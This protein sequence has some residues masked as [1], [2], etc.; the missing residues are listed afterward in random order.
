MALSRPD[1]LGVERTAGWVPTDDT[2]RQRGI[3]PAALFLVPNRWTPMGLTALGH[4]LTVNIP[5][6]GLVVTAADLAIPYQ[7]LHFQVARSFDAQEQYAQYA[8]LDSHPNTDPRIHFFA[9]WQLAQEANVSAVWHETFPELLVAD[10]DG[11]TGLYYRTYPTFAMN[12]RDRF[13]VEARLRAYGVPGRTLGALGWSYDD[14]DAILRSRQGT[15]SILAGNFVPETMVDPAVVKLFRFDATTG[16]AHRYSSDFAYHELIDP[17]GM[18]EVTVQALL[19]DS[20]DALGHSVRF[21][22][23]EPTPPHRSYRITDGTGRAFRLD[24]EDHVEYLDGELPGSHVKAFVVSRAADETRAADNTVEYRYDNGRLVETRYPGHA[25]GPARVRRYDYDARGCLVGITDP[26]GDKFTIEYVEDVYDC[27]DRLMPRLKVSR[28]T[29]AEGNAAAYHYDHAHGQVTVTFTGTDGQTRKVTY[30]YVED[31]TDT[32]QRYVTSEVIAVQAGS[33]GNQQVRTS[34]QYSTDG[35]FRLVAATDPLGGTTRYTHNDYNQVTSQIDALGHERDYAYDTRDDPAPAE[36]NAYD[37]LAVSETNIDG[38]GNTFLVRSTATF[39]RYDT[40]TSGD[41]QDAGLSTHRIST[42]TDEL[43]N[44]TTF[45]YDD[46]GSN[47]PLRPTTYTNALGH[48]TLRAYDAAGALVRE[49]DPVGSTSRWAYNLQGQLVSSIDP[50]GFERHWVYDA[51]SSWL[52]DATDA[53]GAAPGDPQHSIH[54]EWTAAGQLSRARDPAGDITDYAYYANKRIRSITRYDPTARTTSFTFDAPGGLAQI[55]DP[56]G[57]TTYFS[58]DEAGRVYTT[59]RDAPGNPSIALRFDL[60]GH[61]VEVTDRSGQI[62]RY[63]YDTLGRV[64]RIEEPDWPAHAPANPG[65]TVVIG[66][67]ELG[68][69]L[70]LRDSELAHEC[71][72]AYDAAGNLI[73]RT[74]GFGSELLYAYDATN[75]LGRLY[76]N[77]GVI[78]IHFVRDQAGRV[79]RV[80]DSAWRDPSRTFRF[81]RAHGSLVDNLYRIEGPAH[82]VARFS[83][84]ANRRLTEA[85]HERAGSPFAT[86][87]YEYRDDGLIG[88]ATGDHSGTYGYD[89][90]KRLTRETDS[91][92]ADAYDGSGNRLWRAAQAP[93]AAQRNVYDDDNRLIQAPS[94]GASYVYDHNGNLLRRESG[95]GT[96]VAYTYDGA[97]RLRVAESGDWRVAYLYDLSGQLLERRRTHGSTTRV[98]RYRYGNRSILAS[99]DGNDN[100]LAL[101]TRSDSGRLLRR[102]SA[103]P[104]TPAPGSDPHSLFYVHDGLASVVGL[105]D[106]DGNDHLG[107][108]YDAWGAPT[109][110]GTAS[111]DPFRYRG[112]FHDPDTG[113]LRSGRR[114]YDPATG[115]WISQDP[116]LTDLLTTQSDL[117]SAYPD[118]ANLY[119]YVGDDPLNHADPTGLGPSEP[120]GGVWNWLRNTILARALDRYEA[121]RKSRPETGV[122]Q[123]PDEQ[124]KKATKPQETPEQDQPD[125]QPE[126]E[127]GAGE[128]SRAPSTERTYK[129]DDPEPTV[130][131]GGGAA[132]AVVGG[133]VIAIGVVVASPVEV[134]AAIG[135]GAV[136]LFALIFD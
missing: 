31:T 93:P 103:D 6:G 53:L 125:P 44:T 48:V 63:D 9:N 131:G 106:Q 55:T 99:L 75:S 92:V 96:E 29:D 69:R 39:G 70:R 100:V 34:W 118:L 5:T 52:T 73:R 85:I 62:T 71:T 115:R 21:G 121:G 11:N 89:G 133:G 45:G 23:V 134:P 84:D 19:V 28:L 59:Y 17:D 123:Q 60:A 102:R 128:G 2:A 113:L 22:P 105:F 86:Y 38:A 83:Y 15:F 90:M 32:R 27:D 120:P 107:V 61:P 40:H 129:Y 33:S 30:S 82:L 72:Y 135:A 51:G 101:Y 111:A 74:D 57:H 130:G 67:D 77:Q 26:V 88:K 42:R 14:F 81:V 76:D 49:T 10:G 116:L 66:Y 110:H 18:R 136:A 16:T 112:S 114:W 58:S 43:G 117:T 95:P 47:V 91:G 108:S 25:G 97:N 79:E 50:N 4:Q 127:P 64:T 104:L 122:K 7:S 119:L 54:Y 36:P 68:R 124:V 109:Q 35:R 37:L 1:Q 56:R 3:D 13:S 80:V 12:T 46:T 126:F 87:G 78:D 65:K 8:Y 94:D 98:T 20:V 41:P 132:A 24:L